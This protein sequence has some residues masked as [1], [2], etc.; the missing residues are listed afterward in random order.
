[1]DSDEE[2]CLLNCDKKIEIRSDTNF[3]AAEQLTRRIAMAKSG[4]SLKKGAKSK[5]GKSI[6]SRPRKKESREITKQLSQDCRCKCAIVC[7]IRGSASIKAGRNRVYRLDVEIARNK[8][9]KAGARQC[10]HDDTT[11]IKGGGRGG[12]VTLE[13]ETKTSVKVKVAGGA[14]PGRFFLQATPSAKC[15][16]K[17]TNKEKACT[18]QFDKVNIAVT[19]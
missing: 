19:N 2:G 7:L 5:V 1:V 4:A 3:S 15:I 6:S 8:G 10:S 18:S 12:R 14:R 17:G 16:C 13:D 9:C 11:W